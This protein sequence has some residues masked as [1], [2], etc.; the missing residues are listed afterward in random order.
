MRSENRP[1]DVELIL[2]EDC[3]DCARNRPIIN[4][5][6]DRVM[7]YI[8]LQDGGCPIGRNELTDMEWQAVAAIKL[9]RDKLNAPKDPK[10]WQEVPEK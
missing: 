9:E 10:G 4:L 5:P 7:H 8:S 2:A 1:E 6:L 3:A